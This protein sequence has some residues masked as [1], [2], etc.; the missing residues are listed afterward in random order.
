MSTRDWQ[1]DR[2]AVFDRD[3]DAC[4][5]CGTTT[6][7]T[8]RRAYPV[9]DVPLEGRVHESA[10]VT[11]CGDCLESL[12]GRADDPTADPDGSPRAALF[13]FARGTTRIQGDAISDVASFA[14]VATSLPEAI[15]GD[16]DDPTTDD[17]DT[18]T[19]A[20]YRRARQDA[21]LAL[22]AVDARLETLESIDDALAED[23]RTALATVTE[24]A[25]DLQTTLGRVVD[26]CERVPAGLERCHG[27]LEERAGGTCSTCGLESRGIDEWR[28]GDVV[29]FDRLFSAINDELQT[30]SGTTTT[31]T[32]QATTLAERLT[33]G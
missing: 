30:A 26:R 7:P 15:A 20:T 22:E 3:D 21:R 16:G 27:C 25:A 12:E 23:V 8:E 33:D 2:A 10:L 13:E 4:R 24:T 5:R 31:L 17:A 14:S 28:D 9:G 19:I 32:E 29:A 18:A 1:A 11:V 6:D